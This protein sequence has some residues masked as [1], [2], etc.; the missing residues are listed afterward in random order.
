MTDFMQSYF[1]AESFAV[2]IPEKSQTGDDYY[3]L[4]S[5]YGAG[6]VRRICFNNS[7]MI[8]MADFIPSVTFEK[9]T[10][11]S[12]DYIEI[13]QF[14]TDSSSWQVGRQRRKKVERGICCYANTS[15]KIY[16]YC[17]ANV[18]TRFVKIIIKQDYFDSFLSVRY[19]DSYDRSKNAVAYLAR[20]PHL[21]E[22]NYIFRQIIDCQAVGSSKE[23]YLESK[24]MEILSLVTFHYENTKDE[25]HIAVKLDKGDIRSLGKSV[26]MMKKNLAGHLTIPELAKVTGMSQSRFQLAFKK[27]YGTTPYDYLKEMRMNHAL[28]LLH[29]SDYNIQTIAARVGY[30][31]AD[32]FSKLFKEIYG[33]SPKKYRDL[34]FIK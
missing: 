28:I 32:H 26:T 30:T 16:A 10:D 8:L 20:N 25:R 13:S 1:D 27:I 9:V 19:R 21:P 31:K 22:L 7:F 2:Y 12:E 4:L 34:H 15:K 24:V 23:I 11:I 33:I 5:E 18:P 3:R 6:S 29:D 17:E 14:E